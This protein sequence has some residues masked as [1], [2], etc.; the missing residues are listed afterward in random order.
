[1]ICQFISHYAIRRLL[2]QIEVEVMQY[3]YDIDLKTDCYVTIQIS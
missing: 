3:P 2:I 1:M